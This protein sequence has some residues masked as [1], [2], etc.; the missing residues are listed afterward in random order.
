MYREYIFVIFLRL[1]LIKFFLLKLAKIKNFEILDFVIDNVDLD[2]KYWINGRKDGS[3]YKY[4]GSN[5]LINSDV[6]PDFN[7]DNK[8][9]LNFDPEDECFKNDESDSTS[10]RFICEY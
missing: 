10:F 7:V 9:M 8:N 1:Y 3:Q 5:E 6:C 2:H 4:F